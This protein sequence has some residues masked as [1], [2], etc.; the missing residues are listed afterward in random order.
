MSYYQGPYNF[1]SNGGYCV[2]PP[3]PCPPKPCLPTYPLIAVGTGVTGPYGPT[4]FNGS[5]G[6]DKGNAGAQAGGPL[7]T[8]PRASLR[9]PLGTF[10]DLNEHNIYNCIPNSN[11]TI[12]F[13][14]GVNPLMTV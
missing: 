5:T 1:Q 6:S 12:I 11:T 13:H 4:G 9:P 7:V 10:G 2:P 3:A 14:P 8:T